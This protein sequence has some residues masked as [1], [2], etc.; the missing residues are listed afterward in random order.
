MA[1]VVRNPESREGKTPNRLV[2]GGDGLISHSRPS[3]VHTRMSPCLLCHL[4]GRYGDR[5]TCLGQWYNQH[6]SE[7]GSYTHTQKNLGGGRGGGEKNGT[8]KKFRFSLSFDPGEV[9]AWQRH[10]RWC[11]SIKETTNSTSSEE[12]RSVGPVGG[13]Q[14]DTKRI[15]DAPQPEGGGPPPKNKI[16]RRKTRLASLRIPLKGASKRL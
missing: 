6:N 10:Q 13:A 5:Q 3:P 16:K 12:Q 1:I 8:T 2:G 4:I 14:T 7:D 15:E 9:S 11:N